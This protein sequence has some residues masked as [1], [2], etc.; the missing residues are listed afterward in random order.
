MF[1]YYYYVYYSSMYFV[2][3]T[4]CASEHNNS[5]SA[6]KVTKIYTSAIAHLSAFGPSMV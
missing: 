2:A 1:Q 3:H 5:F 6:A 4:L